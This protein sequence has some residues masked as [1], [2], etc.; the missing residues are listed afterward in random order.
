MTIKIGTEF[1]YPYADSD[2]V[3]VVKKHPIGNTAYEC[4][5]HESDPD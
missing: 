5:I 2:P 4:V 1:R 3:W